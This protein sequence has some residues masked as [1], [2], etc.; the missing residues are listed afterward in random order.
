MV[1]LVFHFS[2]NIRVI[3]FSHPSRYFL[4]VVVLLFSFKTFKRNKDW[5]S[6]A[7]LFTQDLLHS[8]NSARVNFNYATVFFNQLSSDI[9][10]QK[11]QLPFIIDSY[12]KALAIDPNEK[13]ALTNLG[14]CYY[15]L[16]DYNT[17]IYY[18]KKALALAK[19]DYSLQSNLADAY[20]RNNNLA[21]IGLPR[22]IIILD[23][24]PLLGSGKIDYPAVKVIVEQQQLDT[25]ESEEDQE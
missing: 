17:S 24:V 22:K 15:K 23:T 20:F 6:N 18:T 25:D 7:T 13:G 5:K 16:K 14:V 11:Q 12:K 9:E 3:S 2:K 10:L 1:F 4:A 21:E 19:T 8:P